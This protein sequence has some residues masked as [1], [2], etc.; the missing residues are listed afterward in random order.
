[1]G[2]A[3][4]IGGGRI[5]VLAFMLAALV[6]VILIFGLALVISKGQSPLLSALR[7]STARIKRYGGYVLILVGV[8]L[9]ALSIFADLFAR[10]F[11]V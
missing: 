5:A 7:A 10:L 1:M 6:M 4:T 3:I 2:H 8:W 9:I 11:P